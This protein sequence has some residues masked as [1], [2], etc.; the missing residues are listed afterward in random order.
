MEDKIE[1]YQSSIEDV[2]NEISSSL[3][4]II[5][6]GHCALEFNGQRSDRIIKELEILEDTSSFDLPEITRKKRKRTDD[7]PV[8]K[9]SKKEEYIT[10]E[11]KIFTDIVGKKRENFRKLGIK[12]GKSS[13]RRK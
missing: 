8:S 5:I 13:K 9:K 4:D 1:G 7:Q 6:P 3:D 12:K 10:K 2:M 11:Y